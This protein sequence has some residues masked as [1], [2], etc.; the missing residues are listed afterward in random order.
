MRED[1]TEQAPWCDPWV[2]CRRP[3][4]LQQLGG[5]L[6]DGAQTSVLG[7]CGLQDVFLDSCSMAEAVLYHVNM[8]VLF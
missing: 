4:P 2:S 5:G 1:P 7:S 8:T 3:P 6:G